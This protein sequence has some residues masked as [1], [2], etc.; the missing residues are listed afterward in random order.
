MAYRFGISFM[1]GK[2]SEESLI[3]FAYAFEQRTH[4]REKVRPYLIPN[5]QLGDVVCS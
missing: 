4:T 1:A 3:G 5:T 2:W